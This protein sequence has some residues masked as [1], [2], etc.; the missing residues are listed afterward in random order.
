MLAALDIPSNVKS[1]CTCVGLLL[2]CNLNSDIAV[3]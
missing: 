1:E 2:R 3:P